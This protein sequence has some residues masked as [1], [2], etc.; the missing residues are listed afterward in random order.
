MCIFFNEFVN[1][2]VKKNF[3][4][5]FILEDDVDNW[6]CDKLIIGVRDVVEFDF[7]MYV[8]F[9]DNLDKIEDEG[10]KEL[11]SV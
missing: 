5:S 8:L 7:S 11:E 6:L 4:E 10:D 1:G 2:E 9:E 3:D